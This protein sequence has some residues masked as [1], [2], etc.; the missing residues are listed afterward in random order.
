M[1]LATEIVIHVEK[2][3]YLYVGRSLSIQ[4]DRKYWVFTCPDHAFAT[5][6]HNHLVELA[7][8]DDDHKTQCAARFVDLAVD[9][10]K[11]HWQCFHN[12]PSFVKPGDTFDGACF[13]N[14]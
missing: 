1:A 11:E 10:C 8:S 3:R 2:A 14:Y 4:K 6:L 7:I 5:R 12:D 13:F 9:S